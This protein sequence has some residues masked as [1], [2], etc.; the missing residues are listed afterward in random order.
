MVGWLEQ[1]NYGAERR[2]KVVSSR[3]DS[4]FDDW[5]ALSVDPAVNGYLFRTREG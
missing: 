3:L 1:L 2:R 5:K 4:P